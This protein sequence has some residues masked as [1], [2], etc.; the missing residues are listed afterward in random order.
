MEQLFCSRCNLSIEDCEC[1]K[2][3]DIPEPDNG[4]WFEDPDM[5]DQ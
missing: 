1:K 2:E 4:N 3:E 5:G